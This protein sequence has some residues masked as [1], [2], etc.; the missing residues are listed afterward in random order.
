MTE[1]E[2][3]NG[4]PRHYAKIST[5]VLLMISREDNSLST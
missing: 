2:N 5:K 1:E 3:K 4:K